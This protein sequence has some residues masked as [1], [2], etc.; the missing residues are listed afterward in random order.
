ME[1]GCVALLVG[2]L[3]G[4]DEAVLASPGAGSQRGMPS[5]ESSTTSPQRQH[6][7]P[8]RHH[9]DVKGGGARAAVLGVNDGLVSNVALVLG[10]AGAHPT[11]ATVRL[12]GLVG[13]VGG[14]CSMAIGEYISMRGQKELFERELA[15]ESEEIAAHPRAE[16]RELQAI[17]QDRGASAGVA[18]E[19]AAELMEDR[20]TALEAHARDELGLDPEELGSPVQAA[21]SSLASFALGAFVPLV[22]WFFLASSAAIWLSVGLTAVASAAVGAAL[23]ATAGRSVFRTSARQ[24]LLAAA[25]AAITFGVGRA[26]GTSGLTG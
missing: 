24:V 5:R 17:Y 2:H 21:V 4:W 25:A 22:A 15:V 23:G 16:R 3:G 6:F 7:Q 18:G 12:A 1:L 10:V 20:E 9:R 13:L 14:A 11:A 8:E 26:L 19:L